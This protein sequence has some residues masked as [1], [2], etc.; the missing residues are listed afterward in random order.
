MGIQQ[1]KTFKSFQIILQGPYPPPL[2]FLHKYEALKKVLQ[3]I[4][5]RVKPPPPPP[6]LGNVHIQTIFFVLFLNMA[7]LPV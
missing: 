2:D 5:G 1:Y 3:K 7:P 4:W 6:L